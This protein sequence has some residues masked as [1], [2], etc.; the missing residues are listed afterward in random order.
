MV[1]DFFSKIPCGVGGV[2]GLGRGGPGAL[3]LGG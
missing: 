3:V 1:N 2:Q